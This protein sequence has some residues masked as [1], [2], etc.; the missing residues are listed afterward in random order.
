MGLSWETTRAKRDVISTCC[1][2]TGRTS[3]NFLC[4]KLRVRILPRALL[5]RRL[6]AC[7]RRSA[8]SDA[9]G[10]T[11]GVSENS[12]TLSRRR[13]RPVEE[14][15]QILARVRREVSVAL[16]RRDVR[17]TEPLLDHLGRDAP[18]VAVRSERVPQQMRV[19]VLVETALASGLHD[20]PP[21][22]VA[23]D[24]AAALP[25]EDQVVRP[26]VILPMLIEGDENL[27]AQGDG[28]RLAPVSFTAC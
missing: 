24:V 5:E 18:L 26:A 20:H 12:H 19:H 21:E 16:G 4:L 28:A 9:V 23:V 2:C 17:V 6:H 25:G 3:L 8:F 22:L 15:D 11:C 10:V 27:L 1:G 14:V 13:S 7:R